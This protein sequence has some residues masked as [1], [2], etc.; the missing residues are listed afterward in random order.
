M[1]LGGPERLDRLNAAVE[2][3]RE[4][5]SRPRYAKA[6][7]QL[8]AVR[9][10]AGEHAEAALLTTEAGELAMAHMAHDLARRESLAGSASGPLRA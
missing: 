8:A 3:L 1:V 6:L 10:D 5:P 7:L 9:R 4:S 2:V